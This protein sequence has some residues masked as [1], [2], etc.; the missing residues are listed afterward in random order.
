MMEVGLRAGF[1]DLGI[2]C[3]DGEGNA[4]GSKFP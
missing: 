4:Q 2:F 3:E 1:A